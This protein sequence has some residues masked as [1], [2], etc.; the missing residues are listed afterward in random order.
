MGKDTRK[1]HLMLSGLRSLLAG[2]RRWPHKMV[3]AARFPGSQ[4]QPRP[5]PTNYLCDPRAMFTHQ[6][7][8]RMES[9]L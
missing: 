6:A 4:S 5:P 3:L 1:L 8:V 2:G 7:L 9:E